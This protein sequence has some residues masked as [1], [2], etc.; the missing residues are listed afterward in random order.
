MKIISEG[1]GID[2]DFGYVRIDNWNDE[3]TSE[4][5]KHYKIILD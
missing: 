3:T 1:T 4:I 5:A 2:E